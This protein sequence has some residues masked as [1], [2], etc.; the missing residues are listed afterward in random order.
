MAQGL[1]HRALFSRITVLVQQEVGERMA[2]RPG[3]RAS[4]TIT[5]NDSFM[6]SF[7]N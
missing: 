3:S 2:A 6:H 7:G 1:E 4:L 5:G